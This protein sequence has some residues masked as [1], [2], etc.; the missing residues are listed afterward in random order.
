MQVGYGGVWWGQVGRIDVDFSILARRMLCFMFVSTWIVCALVTSGLCT[1]IPPSDP[2][3]IPR[4]SKRIQA[5]L[6]REAPHSTVLRFPPG[7][8]GSD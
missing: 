8:F 7:L 6:R 3:S 5:Y 4:H 1:L 2:L